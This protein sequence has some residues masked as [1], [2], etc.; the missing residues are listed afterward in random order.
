MIDENNVARGVE[1]VDKDG[2]NHTINATK[3][4]IL[5]AGTIGSA[6]LLLLSGKPL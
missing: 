6:Q 2:N 5:S 1:F 4:V 3:E